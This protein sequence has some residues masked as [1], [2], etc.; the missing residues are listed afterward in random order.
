MEGCSCFQPDL[1]QGL[2]LVACRG[3]QRLHYLKVQAQ[4]QSL[5][6]LSPAELT[7]S[8]SRSDI[9]G[10]AGLPVVLT[11]VDHILYLLFMIR[12]VDYNWQLG[13]DIHVVKPVPLKNC[14]HPR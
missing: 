11:G 6:S 10:S 5:K 14:I 12:N 13:H 7:V 1:Q 3:V 8:S 4:G 2:S 9:P